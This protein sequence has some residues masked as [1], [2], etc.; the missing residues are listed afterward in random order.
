M[1]ETKLDF[2]PYSKK[3]LKQLKA[4]VKRMAEDYKAREEE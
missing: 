3:E 4:N 1:T 2:K